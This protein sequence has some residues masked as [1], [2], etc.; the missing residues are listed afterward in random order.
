M[1]GDPPLFPVQVEAVVAITLG[2]HA[3]EM[4]D[5]RRFHLF[6]GQAV[7]APDDH[8]G[9]ANDALGDPAVVVFVESLG[10]PLCGAEQTIGIVH[11][12]LES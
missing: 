11:V 5:H 4:G 10:E 8:R 7:D 9:P 1:V 3:L 12:D 2:R 6:A